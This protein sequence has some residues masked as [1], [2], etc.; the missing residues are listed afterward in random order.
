MSGTGG[1]PAGPVT[2]SLLAMVPMGRAGRPEEVA[3]AALYLASD[4]ASYTSG[5]ALFVNGG[6]LW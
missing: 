3:R 6:R 5:T 4:A 1:P 2:D